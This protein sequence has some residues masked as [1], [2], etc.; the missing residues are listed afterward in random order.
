MNNFRDRTAEQVNAAITSMN[1]QNRLGASLLVTAL[2]LPVMIL[3]MLYFGTSGEATWSLV[4]VVLV[5]LPGAWLWYRI[6]NPFSSRIINEEVR[7][8]GTA[9]HGGARNG[10][11]WVIRIDSIGRALLI[12]KWGWLEVSDHEGRRTGVVRWN[13]VREQAALAQALQERGRLSIDSRKLVWRW[14]P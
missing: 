9:I 11:A 13:C 14:E 4:A 12:E 5:A 3:I 2:T 10:E 1:R 6:V 7:F 8:D